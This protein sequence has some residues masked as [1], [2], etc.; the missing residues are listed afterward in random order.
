MDWELLID[1]RKQQIRWTKMKDAE[2]PDPIG[3]AFEQVGESA[4]VVYSDTG[5]HTGPDL[6]RGEELG[7]STLKEACDR[8]GKGWATL[9]DWR[10][11]FYRRHTG[12]N[13]SSKRQAFLR[14]RGSLVGKGLVV[15]DNDVYRPSVTSVTKRDDGT[16]VTGCRRDNRDTT[17]KGVTSVTHPDPLLPM[18]NIPFEVVS[19]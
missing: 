4:V 16:N 13:I 15:A 6:T 11:D 5:Q 17:L 12:D 8:L 10:R 9:N 19:C 2:I 14:I 1:K 3:F 7:L 18:V